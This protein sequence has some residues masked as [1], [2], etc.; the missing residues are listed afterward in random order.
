VAD[1]IVPAFLPKPDGETGSI[2]AGDRK[3]MP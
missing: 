1:G 3:P 2:G